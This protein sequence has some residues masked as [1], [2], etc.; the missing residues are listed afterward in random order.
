[1]Q[2]KKHF[3]AMAQL[4]SELPDHKHRRHL[5][6]MNADNFAKENPRFDKNRFFRACGLPQ[7]ID[8][9]DYPRFK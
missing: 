4:L 6:I 3:V 5:A 1:M 7:D 8:E 2:T 9:I